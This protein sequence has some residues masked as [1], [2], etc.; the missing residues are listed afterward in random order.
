MTAL[1]IVWRELLLAS[2]RSATYWARFLTVLAGMIP[3]AFVLIGALPVSSSSQLG[4][5]LFYI[6]SFLSFLVALVGPVRLPADSLSSEKR[7]GTLGFLFLTDLKAYDVVLGK[8]AASSLGGLYALLAL[9]PILAIPI[10]YGGVTLGDFGRLVLALLNAL[11]FGLSL[12]LL[13]SSLC[14]QARTA[15]GMTF[16]LLIAFGGIVPPVCVAV[17][18][19]T[20]STAPNPFLFSFPCPLFAL[21]L[22]LERVYVMSPAAFWVSLGVT[23]V[24]AWGFFLLCCRV[25][26]RSWQDRPAEKRRLHFREWYRQLVLGSRPVRVAFRRRALARNPIFWLGSREI[27]VVW[28][29]WV[30]LAGMAGV[31]LF[32]AWTMTV[33]SVEFEALLGIGFGLHFFFKYWIAT[34]AAHAFSAD[35]DKGALE[36]LL[37]TPVGVK[38]MVAGHALTLRRMLLAPIAFVLALELAGWACAVATASESG[39]G[40]FWGS[41]AFFG[42]V[43]VFVADLVSV[44]WVGWWQGVVAKTAG[45][46]ASSTYFR[47]CFFPTALMAIGLLLVNAVAWFVNGSTGEVPGWVSLAL[48]VGL[49]FAADVVF[50]QRARR[51]LLTG[52]REAAAARY[53]HAET[54]PGLWRQFKGAFAQQVEQAAK[55]N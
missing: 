12:A 42:A 36:L 17:L 32:Y 49:S 23:H 38:S 47:I 14:W 45:Q 13:I 16:L 41:L 30:F 11:F 4:I 28:H 29:P 44:V 55:G 54:A 48:Y 8:L 10:L 18:E 9:I 7:E 1:P 33:R 6:L 25:L 26:P 24:T 22:A 34:L 50:T 35:R 39:L 27:R 19:S 53:G 3:T 2:R 52:L 43:A 21:F 51:R 5:E 40:R 15:T 46:A 31:G 20:R 37:S